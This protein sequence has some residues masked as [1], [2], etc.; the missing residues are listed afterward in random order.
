MT[1]IYWGVDGIYQI[2]PGNV[3]D[4]IVKSLTDATIQTFYTELSVD[5][6]ANALGVYDEVTKTAR[7]IYYDKLQLGLESGTKELILDTHIGSFYKYLIKNHPST[8]V[9]GMFTLPTFRFEESELNVMVGSDE[10]LSGSDNVVVP[11]QLR[12]PTKSSVKYLTFYGA[13]DLE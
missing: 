10:V 3:G 8:F 9:R 2:T 7:W 13:G 6:K 12:V 5:E 11:Y 1:V 4:L